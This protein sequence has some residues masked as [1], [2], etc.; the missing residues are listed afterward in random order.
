[1]WLLSFTAM[2]RQLKLF[3]EIGISGL[4]ENPTWMRCQEIVLTEVLSLPTA[5]G[6][7]H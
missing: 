7:R 6:R 2:Q 4:E 1:M 3:K 5:I